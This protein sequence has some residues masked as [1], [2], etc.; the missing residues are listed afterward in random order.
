[1]PKSHMLTAESMPVLPALQVRVGMRVI[2]CMH[3][4]GASVA[5]VH[6]GEAQHERCER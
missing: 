1:M 6:E 4:A 5:H 2:V 3:H